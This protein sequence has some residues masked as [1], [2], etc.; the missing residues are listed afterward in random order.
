MCNVENGIE[1]LKRSKVMV[2]ANT[3]GV[4]IKQVVVVIENALRVRLP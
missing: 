1:T 4:E 3:D 2:G